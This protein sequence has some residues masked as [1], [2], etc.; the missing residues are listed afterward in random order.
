MKKSH[1]WRYT[2][3]AFF[4][5]ILSVAGYS[6]F[7]KLGAEHHVRMLFGKV[8]ES[9]FSERRTWVETFRDSTASAE[10]LSAMNA[11]LTEIYAS[12]FTEK[13]FSQCLSNRIFTKPVILSPNEPFTIQNLDL[14]EFKYTSPFEKWYDYILILENQTTTFNSSGQLHLIRENTQWKVDSWNIQ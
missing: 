13:G 1:R 14:Q 6:L 9:S 2:L 12:Y 5:V 10:D 4:C 11:A 8:F 7:L 3:I